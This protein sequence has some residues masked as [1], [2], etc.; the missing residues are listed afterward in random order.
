MTLVQYAIRRL[1]EAYDS[2][3]DSSGNVGGSAA[4]LAELHAQI[5]AE[6]RPDPI[7]LA[8]W[9]LDFQTSGRSAP[10]LGLESYTDPLGEPGLAHYG[11]QV[12][13]RWHT[14]AADDPEGPDFQITYLMES[15]AHIHGDVDLLITVL[16]TNRRHGAAYPQIVDALTK[17]G[18]DAEALAWAER[19]LA[20]SG[21]RVPGNLV[22]FVA[23]RYAEAGRLADVL[24]LRRNHFLRARDLPAYQALRTAAEAADDWPETR[25]W[26]LDQLRPKGDHPHPTVRTY[27]HNVLVDVLL[28]EG[29]SDAAWTAAQQHSA[30]DAQWSRLAGLREAT[31][32]EDA[33]GVYQ[34]LITQKV[35]S[36]GGEYGAAA[37]LAVRV[38]ALYA[39]IDAPDAAELET[40]YLT[41][42]RAAHKRKRN[43]MAELNR[44]G[45]P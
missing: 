24:A 7:A 25:A 18:R 5:C 6:I 42:L 8:D 14:A 15:W 17:A 32:P 16:S 3:D 30:T 2:I 20:D 13:A 36:G 39:R 41:G 10:E 31:H 9:L 19:G 44:R 1:G 12:A 34:R 40:T 27:Y 35:D 29:D 26:A 37:D 11:Q 33:I 38:Q 22:D 4:E 23:A 21:H 45:L 28:W 43:F